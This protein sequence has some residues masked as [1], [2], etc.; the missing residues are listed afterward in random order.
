MDDRELHQRSMNIGAHLAW[1]AAFL[2]SANAADEQHN[3]LA[4]AF[5]YYYSTFHAGFAL[6]NTN[7]TFH[8][9]DMERIHHNKVELY[10]ENNLPLSLVQKAK[11]LRVTREFLSYLGADDPASKLR[12]VRGHGIATALGTRDVRGLVD[13]AR[14]DSEEIFK[15]IYATVEAF[16]KTHKWQPLQHGREYYVDEYLDEDILLNVIPREGDG[17]KLM[18]RTVN[19]L[20]SEDN[21]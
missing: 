10:L 19:L 15:Y 16:C 1:S 21:V 3:L 2:V 6:I 13:I 4:A 8:M 7:H 17:A 20:L 18:R 5:S 11:N 9:P 12:I 14:A